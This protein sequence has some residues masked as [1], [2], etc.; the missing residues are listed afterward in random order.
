MSEVLSKLS[1]FNVLDKSH[2]AKTLAELQSKSCEL[3]VISIKILKEIV[4]FLIDPI[5][6]IVNISLSK[7]QF[8]SEWKTAI[9]RPL[10]K[11]KLGQDTSRNNYRPVGNLNFLS[12]LVEKCALDQYTNHLILH[13]LHSKHQS[14]YKAGHS[15]ESALLKI[16]SDIFWSVEKKI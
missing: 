6:R 12:K 9:L 7:G 8:A 5:T 15:C 2:I 10:Q 4:D 13:S 3:D 14:A 1:E 16:C 11:K